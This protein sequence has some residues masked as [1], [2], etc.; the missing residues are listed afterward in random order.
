LFVRINE[1]R[2]ASAGHGVAVEE[3]LAEFDTRFAAI[4]GRFGRM[5][6]RRQARAFLLGL[7]SDVDSRSC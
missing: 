2:A 4:A 1:D 7:L 6:P 3:W 5:E